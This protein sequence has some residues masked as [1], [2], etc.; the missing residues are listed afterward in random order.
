MNFSQTGLY[1]YFL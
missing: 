1:R